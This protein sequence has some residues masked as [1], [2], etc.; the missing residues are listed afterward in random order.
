MEQFNFCKCSLAWRTS[1]CFLVESNLVWRTRN[2]CFYY[3]RLLPWVQIILTFLL[4]L[5]K[6]R[7]LPSRRFPIFSILQIIRC[8]YPLNVQKLERTKDI[9]E[10]SYLNR[11]LFRVTPLFLWIFP[12]FFQLLLIRTNTK[13][14]FILV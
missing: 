14:E 11:A 1:P 13:W 10:K 2:I 12:P 9:D 8:L 7:L 6:K 4:L 3:Q 5:V